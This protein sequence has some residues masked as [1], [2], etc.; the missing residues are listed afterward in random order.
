MDKDGTSHEKGL[1]CC[2]IARSTHPP[3]DYPR[4]G[5]NARKLAP[6]H[7]HPPHVS[8]R[9][10][11]GASQLARP[12]YHVGFLD[13]TLKVLRS[14]CFHCSRL[15]LDKSD[16]KYKRAL[17]IKNPKVC[18]FFIEKGYCYAHLWEERGKGG[19]RRVW[20]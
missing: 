9:A 17:M 10:S 20:Q 4:E 7:P 8:P 18:E 3:I 14:V 5:R 12:V 1:R 2:K 19:W 6:H 15:R 13:V 16:I 11:T